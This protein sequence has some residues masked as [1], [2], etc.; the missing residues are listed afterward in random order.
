MEDQYSNIQEGDAKF[1]IDD[2][3]IQASI[4]DMT[5]YFNGYF[6]KRAVNELTPKS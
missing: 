4:S 6:L 2:E 1:N 5:A 3:P